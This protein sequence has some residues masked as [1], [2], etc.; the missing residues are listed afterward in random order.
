MV[1][2][3]FTIIFRRDFFQFLK[4]LDKITQIVKS[5]TVRDLGDALVWTDEFSGG[6]FDT[7]GE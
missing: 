2:L 1:F 5:A 6:A 3:F 4:G 7:V